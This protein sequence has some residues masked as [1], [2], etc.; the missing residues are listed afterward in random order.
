MSF[1]VYESTVNDIKN[2]FQTGELQSCQQL[3]SLFEDRID[4]YEPTLNAFISINTN[5]QSDA[6]ALDNLTQEEKASKPL[7]CIPFVAKDNYATSS[8]EFDL[9][10]TVGSIY[11][12]DQYTEVNAYMVQRLLDAGGVLMGK[13]NMAEFAISGSNTNSSVAG[14][15]RNAYDLTKS[16]EGSSGGTATAVA[17]SFCVLGLGTDTQGSIQNPAS[18]QS[19][20][21][22]R[23]T[24]AMLDWEGIFPALDFQD[25]GGPITRSVSDLS[26]AMQA[27]DSGKPAGVFFYP[28]PLYPVNPPQQSLPLDG[29]RIGFMNSTINPAKFSDHMVD[30]QVQEGMNQ[31]INDLKTLGATVVILKGV[32][33]RSHLST[34]NDNIGLECGCSEE[35]ASINYYLEHRVTPSSP[36]HNWVEFLD[37]LS[38]DSAEPDSIIK[39][40]NLVNKCA[41]HDYTAVY[42]KTCQNY[43]FYKTALARWLE[44]NLEKENLDGYLYASMME[45]AQTI[46]TSM[47]ASFS[48]LSAYSTLPALVIQAGTSTSVDPPMPFGASLMARRYQEKQLLDWAIALEALHNHRQAPDTYAPPL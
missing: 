10:T 26:Y 18:V 19:L 31:M 44:E 33:D 24:T 17:A 9:P 2:A 6:A 32:A 13:T 40:M 5:A 11:L 27:I 39:S 45:T 25:V 48:F 30:P 35:K 37:G 47:P 3:V 14:Q 43:H 42:F 15:T 46:G 21:G 36:A 20:V 41:L 12:K 23:S 34:F 1:Q 16:P 7:W 38:N 28:T 29:V 8:K 22:L 4:A